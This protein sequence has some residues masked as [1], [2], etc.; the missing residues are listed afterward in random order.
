[1]LS[2]QLGHGFPGLHL[3]LVIGLGF[4]Q[5]RR[6]LAFPVL[7]QQP[8]VQQGRLGVRLAGAQSLHQLAFPV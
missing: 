3:P 1:M 7:A 4:L 5:K 2:N 8:Q 6:V